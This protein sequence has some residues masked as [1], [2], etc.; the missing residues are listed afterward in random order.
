MLGASQGS[1]VSSTDVSVEENS[2]VVSVGSTVDELIVEPIELEASAL[3]GIQ[4]PSEQTSPDK[5]CP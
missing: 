1:L 3:S 4:V 2:V 5:H